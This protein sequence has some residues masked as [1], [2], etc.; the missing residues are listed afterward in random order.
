MTAK[1]ASILD[2][3]REWEQLTTFLDHPDPHVR[4][5]VVSGRRRVGKSFLL[6]ALAE[7]HGSL[8]VTAVAEEDPVAARR[9]FAAAV[10]RYAG[11]STLRATDADWEEL[12]DAALE[13]VVGKNGPSG[14]LVIDELPYWLAHSPQLTG[15][16]QLAYD[17]SQAG[18]GVAGG[19]IVLCGSAISV[20]ESLLS[21]TKALRG[22]AVLD[23]R[24]SPFGVRTTAE[25]WGIAD[26][27]AALAVHATLGGAPGYANLS[28]APAPQN[29]REFDEWVP[30]TVLN[31]GQAI[32]S[33]VET[34]YLLR[35][36][37]KFSG[38]ALHYAILSAVAQGANTPAKIG[39]LVERDRTALVRPLDALISAGYLVHESDL[40]WQRKPLITIGD[41]I[42][43]F[44]NLITVPQ[45]DLL[46][47]G[48]PQEAWEAARATFL[49]R[50]LGPHF[51]QTAR[52]WTRRYAADEA[53]HGSFP[54]RVG[55]TAVNDRSGRAKHEIDVLAIDPAHQ[56]GSGPARIRLV[57]EAKATVTRRGLADLT[58]LD[59]LRESLKAL[60]HKVDDSIVA[61]YALNGFYPDLAAAA[62]NRGDVL[63]ID[64]A[65]MSGRTEPIVRPTPHW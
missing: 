5:G 62:R 64:L 13:V 44:H 43:R 15:L 57:G 45:N 35:E 49:S 10:N 16:L 32:Y 56:P 42:I 40:L 6:R 11:L 25:L 33:R 22:R 20:M 54:G 37:P 29:S 61:I 1:P 17:R 23:L 4:I 26:P 2:R 12:L 19:R 24:V 50:V 9:R 51:E 59:G 7:S 30:A 31:P 60:G 65:G 27:A 38:Q 36:D 52:D 21:G 39:G 63:L 18:V 28:P 8:Y 58:R 46:E 53:F 14:L 41:P 3:D 55:S 47:V 48:R 34:E